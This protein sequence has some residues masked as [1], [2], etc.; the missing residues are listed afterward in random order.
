[1]TPGRAGTPPAARGRC[2]LAPHQEGMIPS[3]DLPGSAFRTGQGEDPD[4]S[5]AQKS[6]DHEDILA[7]GPARERIE[8]HKAGMKVKSEA[9]RV[10]ERMSKNRERDHEVGKGGVDR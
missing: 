6:E 8:K 1:M 3:L 5:E 9:A 10:S 2:P 7:A 4:R